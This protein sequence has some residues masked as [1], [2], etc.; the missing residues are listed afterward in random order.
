MNVLKTPY[1]S[2][3]KQVPLVCIFKPHGSVNWIKKC[4]KE[5]Q[6]NDYHLLKDN[7]V[8]IDIV[9]P[10]RSKYEVGMVNDIFRSHREIFNELISDSRKDF[11]TIKH[12]FVIKALQHE[13]WTLFYHDVDD[14]KDVLDKDYMIYKC[15]KYIIN[16]PLWDMDIFTDTFL[17]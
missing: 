12:S 17:G 2:Y 1:T 4:D 15:K 13:N 10:G 8:N 11:S 5:Y 16:Q 14:E 6:I 9:A 7:K 3:R